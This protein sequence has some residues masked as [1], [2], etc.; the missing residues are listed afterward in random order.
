MKITCSNCRHFHA[1]LSD[2]KTEDHFHNYC[3]MWRLVVANPPRTMLTG[4]VEELRYDVERVYDPNKPD[5]MP[6]FYNDLDCGLAGCYMFAP[7]GANTDENDARLRNNFNS[8][9]EVALKT[10]ELILSTKKITNVENGE[11]IDLPDDLAERLKNVK[12]TIENM[13]A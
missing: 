11:L 3:D 7:N 10:L 6:I 4:V 5:E 12:A 8:M 13:K 1:C 2:V 9:K